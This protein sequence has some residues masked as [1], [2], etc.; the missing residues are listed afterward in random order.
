[1]AAKELTR[2]ERDIAIIEQT[3]R[4]MIQ[5]DPAVVQLRVDRYQQSTAH[6]SVLQ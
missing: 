5:T 1:M 6:A 4:A 3:L 2:I